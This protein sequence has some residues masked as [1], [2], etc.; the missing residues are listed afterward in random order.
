MIEKWH[1]A[2]AGSVT[3][4]CCKYLLARNI[5]K[6][7]LYP[8]KY[9]FSRDS[10]WKYAYTIHVPQ[11]V[12]IEMAKRMKM[13]YLF[14]KATN[15]PY[16]EDRSYFREVL[17]TMRKY[18]PNFEWHL[19]DG[20]HHLHLTNPTSVSKLIGSFLTKHRGEDTVSKL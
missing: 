6:S 5:A 19:V 9:Y 3:K 7:T 1:E 14:I 11:D 15:S 20:T 2:T 18:N 8:D 12:S 10:R 13:P 4:E 17:S 16:Y